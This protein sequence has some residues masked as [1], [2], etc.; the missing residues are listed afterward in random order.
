MRYPAP[1]ALFFDQSMGAVPEGTPFI[2]EGPM[3]LPGNYTVKLTVDGVASVQPVLLKEDPRLD[4]SPAATDGMR[5]Q[6]ALSQQITTVMSASKSAYEQAIGLDEQ[7]T[8]LGTDMSSRDLK[9]LQKEGAKLT[10]SVKDASLGLSGGSYAPP[11][12]KGLTSF[13]RINGQAS[14]LLEMVESTSDE[15][16]VPSLYRT[17]SELCGDFNATLAAWQSLEAKASGWRAGSKLA[18]RAQGITS[19]PLSPLACGTEGPS[20]AQTR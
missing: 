16:P 18:G 4:D 12:V 2:P 5:R 14:A 8:S 10:G 20:V 3:V 13:S 19:K 15:A 9:A 11:P 7:L 6:L 17:Y 1:P